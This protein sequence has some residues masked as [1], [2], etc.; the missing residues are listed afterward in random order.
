[1][2]IGVFVTAYLAVA[3]FVAVYLFHYGITALPSERLFS[4]VEHVTLAAAMLLVAALWV[5]FV[6]GL[7][8]QAFRAARRRPRGAFPAWLYHRPRQHARG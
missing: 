5:L 1:M 8:V 4:M 2:T 7:L 6:P 3:A